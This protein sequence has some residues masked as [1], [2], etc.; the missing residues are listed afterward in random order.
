M[1]GRLID[2]RSMGGRSIV[3]RSIVGRRIEVVPLIM[4]ANEQFFENQLN[5]LKLENKTNVPN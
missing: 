3:G 5:L 1:G 4:V 2:V